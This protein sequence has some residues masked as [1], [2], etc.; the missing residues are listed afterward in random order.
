MITCACRMGANAAG[1]SADRIEAVTAFGRH[2]GLAFQIVDDLLDV[3]ST[4]EQMGKA[5]GKDAGKGKNTYPSL[6]GLDASQREA[7]GQL[8]AAL[9]TVQPLGQS[10]AGLRRLASFV[11]ERKS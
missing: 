4:P 5:T 3:T 8:Q 1:A 7:D 11:V 2:L 9:R 6:M 10:G